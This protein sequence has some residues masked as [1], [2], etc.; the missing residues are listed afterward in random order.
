MIWNASYSL[1][2]MLSCRQL[3]LFTSKYY[4]IQLFS[5]DT[6][7]YPLPIYAILSVTMYLLWFTLE[8]G[9]SDWFPTGTM[10]SF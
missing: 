9:I 1:P 8:W 5:V 7:V 2:V 10:D 3:C 6:A 4:N